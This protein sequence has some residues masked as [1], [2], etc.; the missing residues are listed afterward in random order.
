MRAL[1]TGANRGIGAALLCEGT[2][3]GHDVSGISRSGRD[4]ARLDVTDPGS[5]ARVAEA[6]GPLDLL[7]CNAGVYLDRGRG[8]ADLDSATFADTFAV[9]VTGIA[10]TIQA[11]LRNLSD[12]GRI[13]IVAS[14]MGRQSADGGDAFVYRAS[15]AAA[16]NLALNLAVALRGRGIAVAAF[17]SGWVSSDMGGAAAPVSPAVSARGLWDRFEALDLASTGSF[18]NHDGTPLDP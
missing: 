9:N 11:H 16:V 18:L 2:S 13:A 7:V 12:G 10:L 15:K 4:L 6:A 5:Q 8:L 14:A 3:R 1:I 17:H